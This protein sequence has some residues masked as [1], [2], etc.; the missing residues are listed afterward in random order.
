MSTWLVNV[1][2]SRICKLRTTYS[3]HVGGDIV[4]R[5]KKLLKARWEKAAL[6][7]VLEVEED[8]GHFEV[9]SPEYGD[10]ED[11]HIGDI[12]VGVDVPKHQLNLHMVKPEQ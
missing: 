11:A 5:V 4:P 7:T 6:M 2:S 8:C 12:I 3:K 9:V 10:P 1:L